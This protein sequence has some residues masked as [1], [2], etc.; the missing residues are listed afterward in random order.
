VMCRDGE[1]FPVRAGDVIRNRPG[2]IHELSN[3]GPEELRLF[4]FELSVAGQA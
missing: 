4:V 3:P 1:E 2:G